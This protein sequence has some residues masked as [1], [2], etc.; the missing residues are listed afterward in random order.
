[1]GRA[2]PQ[3]QVRHVI[4]DRPEEVPI[5]TVSDPDETTGEFVGTE[6]KLDDTQE[7]EVEFEEVL[8]VRYNGRSDQRILTQDVTTP[9]W[10]VIWTPDSEVPYDFFQQLAGSRERASEILRAHRHEFELVGP[11]A[12]E[13]WSQENGGEVEEFSVGGLVE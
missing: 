9:A 2:E 12:E 8:R 11:G 7:L 3:P 10:G 1:M 6:V 13:F 4:D 5:A